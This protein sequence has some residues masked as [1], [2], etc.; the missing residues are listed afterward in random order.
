MLVCE[1]IQ[2]L[3]SRG[4]EVHII[5]GRGRNLPQDRLTHGVLDLDLD[6]KEDYFLGA[7]RP[8]RFEKMKWHLFNYRSYRAVR[9]T[10]LEIKPDLVVVWNLWVASMGPLIAARRS[11][12]PMVIHTADRWLYYGVKDWSELVGPQN[13]WK[14]RAVRLIRG[15]VQPILYRLA[16][17]HPIITISEFIRQI[18]VTAGFDGSQIEPIHLGIPLE[19]FSCEG[20]LAR[21]PK[22][23]RMLYVGSLWEGKG[24]Q[25]AVQALGK[26]IQR[27][28]LPSVH[29]DFYG[30]GA[31]GFIEYLNWEIK[32][33]GVESLVT[34]HGFVDRKTLPEVFRSHDILL[35]P[36]IWDEPFAAVPIEAMACGMAL[37]ATTAGGT[38][39]AVVD[40]QTG[41][42]IPPRDS[43]AMAD[44]MER[45][46]RDSDLCQRL[47]EQ[48]CRRVKEK[49]SFDAYIKKLEARYESHARE[50]KSRLA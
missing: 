48:A 2:G 26:L 35:F 28:G 32:N 43:D 12:F 24:P 16:K 39:E 8:T 20:R 14:R 18:Y 9:S 38:P 11:G 5:T 17:P 10:L 23:V 1:V 25:I 46:I 30:S 6:H 13:K 47:G 27:P 3:R 36:S 22:Q 21:D 49:W 19:K 34:F 31:P 33:A 44:A 45:L 42:L 37:I 40:G 50:Q 15:T 29:V 4:H 7:R 41:L